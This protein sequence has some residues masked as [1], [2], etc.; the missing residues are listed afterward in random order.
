MRTNLTRLHFYF[1]YD[2]YKQEFGNEI[3]QIELLRKRDFDPA[4][5]HFQNLLFR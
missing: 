5:E 3:Q 2:F 4:S 1:K